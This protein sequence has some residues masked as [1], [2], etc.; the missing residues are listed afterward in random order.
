MNIFNFSKIANTY[1]NASLVQKTSGDTLLTLLDIKEKD[2]VLDVGCGTGNITRKIR[3]LTQGKVVGIDVS[4]GMIKKAN[5][6]SA[7]LQIDFQVMDVDFLKYNNDFNI[8][9]CNSAFQWFRNPD[10]CINNFYNS[11]KTGGKFGM[12][13][14]ATSSYCP[15]FVSAIEKIKQDSRTKDTFSSFKNP[16]F[17]LET[18]DDYSKL[19]SKVGFKVAFS[20]IDTVTSKYTPVEVFKIFSSGAIAGYLNQNFYSKKTDDEYIDSFKEIV[21]TECENQVG[22][23]GF[24][25]LVFNRIFLIAIK[26]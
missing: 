2:N 15:N 26:E 10:K 24:V 5:K 21:K 7:D 22:D 4:D 8:I 6:T 3:S 1:E 16:W 19:F 17:F 18:S 12:Q 14:P 9:F 20:K 11:L 25:D 23:D 13:A